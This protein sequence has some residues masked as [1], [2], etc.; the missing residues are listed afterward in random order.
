MS[1]ADDYKN[2][3]GY[4]TP[5]RLDR[6]SLE[7][8]RIERVLAS[9]N[10]TE[11]GTQ[12]MQPYQERVLSEKSEL[13]R[14]IKNLSAFMRSDEFRALDR[15]E[16]DRLAEQRRIMFTYSNILNQRIIHF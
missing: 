11:K 3:L 16:M 6:W 4:K 10:K 7:Y 12:A 8:I 9:I 14:R 2:N 5:E 13:D 1:Q 15:E